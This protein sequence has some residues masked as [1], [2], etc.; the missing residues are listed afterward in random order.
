MKPKMTELNRPIPESYW[1]VPGKLL[2]GEYPGSIN[3][4]AEKTRRRMNAFL[5]VGF[6]TFIDLTSEEELPDY[7]PVLLEEA[8]HYKK[9]V[10]YRRFAIRDKGLPTLRQMTAILNEIDGALAKNHRVY[11]HCWA[12][13]GR[14]GTTVGCYLARHGKKGMEALYQLAEFWQNVPKSIYFLHSPETDEQ[15]QFILNW[16][17]GREPAEDTDR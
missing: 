6:D 15:V 13:V 9:D 11:L 12:A 14:T 16:S 2:A 1:V 10:Q 8:H 7:L 17:D 3:G 4:E 5:K